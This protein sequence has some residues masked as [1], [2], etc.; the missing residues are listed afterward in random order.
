MDIH[1]SRS[2]MWCSAGT[3]TSLFLGRWHMKPRSSSVTPPSRA[4]R[5]YSTK[6][7]VLQA[8]RPALSRVAGGN[9]QLHACPAAIEGRSINAPS[10]RYF[11][12]P[13]PSPPTAVTSNTHE[14]RLLSKLSRANSTLIVYILSPHSVS[15]MLQVYLSARADWAFPATTRNEGWALVAKTNS[16]SPPGSVGLYRRLVPVG[17]RWYLTPAE[18]IRRLLHAGGQITRGRSSVYAPRQQEKRLEHAVEIIRC[19]TTYR[20]R[21]LRH[22]GT[23]FAGFGPGTNDGC[24][25][26]ITN[27]SSA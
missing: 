26:N 5:R 18:A 4:P 25:N 3:R 20:N 24:G 15:H 14:R 10:Y 27:R 6:K 19:S 12:S 22:M 1:Y 9:E 8:P 16:E 7:A 23:C 17:R 2:Q 11:R 13:M 21:P